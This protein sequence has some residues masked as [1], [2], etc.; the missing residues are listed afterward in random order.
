M[1]CRHAHDKKQ[2]PGLVQQ[3]PVHNNEFILY[4]EN[5]KSKDFMSADQFVVKKPGWLPDSF[6]KEGPD[7]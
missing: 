2:S 3:K 1:T 7:G 6:F 4:Q 5:Y